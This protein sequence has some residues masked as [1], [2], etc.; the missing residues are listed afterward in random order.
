MGSTVT[1]RRRGREYAY[2]VY[3]ND[4]KER[5]E[6]YCGAESN[7][8]TQN[9]LLEVEIEEI[10]IQMDAL[11]RRL[12]ECKSKLEALPGKKITKK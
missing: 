10:E 6:V 3:Y 5:I 12:A 11:R 4:K 9:R 1:R 2:Y 7:P 8:A